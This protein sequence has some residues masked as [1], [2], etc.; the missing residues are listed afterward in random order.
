MYR[1]QA[2]SGIKRVQVPLGELRL[3]V[4]PHDAPDGTLTTCENIRPS[5]PL[6][7][8][9]YSPVV[10]PR[11]MSDDMGTICAIG[12]Q[13]D[14][15]GGKLIVVASDQV[16]VW[17][18]ADPANPTSV[19]TFSATD[20]T[21][22]AQFATIGKR[23]VIAVSS[24]ASPG[25]PDITLILEDTTC[26]R[27]EVPT[28]ASI[29]ITAWADTANGGLTTAGIYG[30]RWAYRFTDGSI[31]P[32]SQPI[33]A[34]LTAPTN[35]WKLTFYNYGYIDSNN[36]VDDSYWDGEIE[37]IIIYL[38]EPY[39]GGASADMYEQLSNLTYYQ[40][41]TWDDP[42]GH[43]VPGETIDLIVSNTELVGGE[44]LEID[45]LQQHVLEGGACFGYN[46]QL[47]LGDVQYDFRKPNPLTTFMDADLTR[48]AGTDY[49]VRLG[50]TIK[51]NTGEYSR[52]SDPVYF[53]SAE[54]ADVEAKG[55]NTGIGW[56]E[57]LIYPDVRA[58]RM[59]IYVDHNNDGVFELFGDAEYE[60]TPGLD[61]A[62][63]WAISNLNLTGHA[64][65][66]TAMPDVTTTNATRDRDPNRMA[67]SEALQPRYFPARWARYCGVDDNNPIMGFAANTMPISEG[68]YGTA[69]LVALS[70]YT[71]EALELD[72]SGAVLFSR[73]IPLS[74]RGAV[75]RTAFANAE[76]LIFFASDDGIWP[77]TPQ[78]GPQPL[79]YKIH[80]HEAVADILD[81]LDYSTSLAYIDDARGN[82]EIW[83][84][85]TAQVWAYSTKYGRWFTMNRVRGA[86]CRDGSKL[87]GYDSNVGE[88][89]E[90]VQHNNDGVSYDARG[91]ASSFSIVT[92]PMTLGAEPGQVKRIYRV[93][94]KQRVGLDFLQYSLF[95]PIDSPEL[96]EDQSLALTTAR[97]VPA[98]GRLVAVDA[99]NINSGGSLIVYGDTWVIG[100]TEGAVVA[101]GSISSDPHYIDGNPQGLCRDLYAVLSGKGKMGQQF[102]AFEFDLEPRYSHRPRRRN[103]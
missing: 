27:L 33:F 4:G 38:S 51:T 103:F 82:R 18:P 97:T 88:L 83:V 20:A 39:V 98:G 6:E 46:Q 14:D 78:L 60:M 9:T 101:A 41:L 1:R 77:L 55:Y 45:N 69:P 67:V 35:T 54:A 74:N 57:A 43:T 62:F 17:D 50:V 53:T 40:V 24:G 99:L 94:F 93:G 56:D 64:G 3:D 68:Q 72:T 70:R 63:N 37:A 22:K 79:S 92:R 73:A 100:S 44:T 86:L 65:T 52:I 76:G 26:K 84:A 96:T 75:S 48:G 102:E 34:V 19:Y 32:P 42:G 49:A 80:A 61:S 81:E 29:E 11:G 13:T 7:R 89:V 71:C 12:R 2:R 21:R 87:Y 59:Q 31:G 90:E 36:P 16:Y 95:A 8:P 58:V 15:S 28:Q 30:Y 91:S 85:T 47:V 10:L 23:T 5:G 25:E 66:E